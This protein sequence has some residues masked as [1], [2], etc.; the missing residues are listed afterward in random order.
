MQKPLM[1]G[2][3]IKKMMKKDEDIG[4]RAD[5]P[6]IP[7]T[8][9]D[10][11]KAAGTSQDAYRDTPIELPQYN[12]EGGDPMA[13]TH[14]FQDLIVGIILSFVIAALILWFAFPQARFYHISGLVIGTVLS[15]IMSFYLRRSV[16]MAIDIGEYEAQRVIKKGA[17]IRYGMACI[18]LGILM[19]FPRGNPLTAFL[20]VMTMKVSAYIQP[21]TNK[22]IKILKIRR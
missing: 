22:V 18:V 19:I 7:D 10:A 6:C 12:T 4:G 17:L 21:F 14:T 11:P 20:G 1:A 13:F 5:S 3:D 16:E 9:G 15:V 2:S 8:K